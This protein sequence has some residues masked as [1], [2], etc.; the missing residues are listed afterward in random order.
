[1]WSGAPWSPNSIPASAV[2]TH[3]SSILTF[4]WTR[5]TWSFYGLCKHQNTCHGQSHLAADLHLKFSFGPNTEFACMFKTKKTINFSTGIQLDP[6]DPPY[7]SKWSSRE[8]SELLKPRYS[9]QLMVRRSRPWSDVKHPGWVFV[10]KT[11][12]AHILKYWDRWM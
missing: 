3:N 4:H 2:L 9:Q 12:L 8:I 7:N 6:P 10:K 5:L 11:C 1:M